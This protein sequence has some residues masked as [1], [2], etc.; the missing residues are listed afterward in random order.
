ML[1]STT[2]PAKRT[3]ADYTALTLIFPRLESCAMREVM[4]ELGRALHEVIQASPDLVLES[5]AALQREL[6]T[7]MDLTT[8]TV[9]PH[10]RV[11]GIQSPMFAV[12]Q[13]AE[14]FGWLAKPFPPTELVFLVAEPSAS[15]L[16]SELLVETLTR[17]R[18]AQ[19][20]LHELILAP[21]AE[22]MLVVLGRF[23]LVSAEELA[24]VQ[25]RRLQLV[26]RYATDRYVPARPR[27]GAVL[28]H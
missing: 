12:G 26:S 23:P 13:A 11:G 4:Q 2:C 5:R 7:G 15:T 10:I 28:A 3:L 27:S 17:L 20:V 21:T 24:L 19:A 16:E 9:V 18:R 6:L 8:G 1:M 22:E 25:A 14:P